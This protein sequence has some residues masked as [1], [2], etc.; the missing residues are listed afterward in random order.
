MMEAREVYV[1]GQRFREA[2]SRGVKSNGVKFYLA[3][4]PED[5]RA[6]HTRSS[7]RGLSAFSGLARRRRSPKRSASVFADTTQP[8]GSTRQKR[9]DEV[10]D[11]LNTADIKAEEKVAGGV[12][13]RSGRRTKPS[14]GSTSISRPRNFGI[15][16]AR[17]A[18]PRATP[19]NWPFATSSS[20]P[21]TW[22]SS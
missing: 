11:L 1:G 20:R 13:A 6:A 12:A 16:P 2:V 8:I 7:G 18:R 21:A 5:E 14:A 9:C 15:R 17:K 22:S 10:L 19:T 3:E 4:H